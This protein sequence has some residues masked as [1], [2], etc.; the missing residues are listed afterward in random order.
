MNRAQFFASAAGDDVSFIEHL[1]R[2]GNRY[3]LDKA[4]T[5]NSLFGALSGGVID[6]K[7]PDIPR[8]D[9]FSTLEK[10]N[11]EK[12]LIGIYLSAHPLDDYRLELTH[13]CNTRLHELD[14]LFAV[15]KR[16]VI[17]GGMVT[18]TRRGTTKKGTPFGIFT[19]EDYSGAYEFPLFG[20]DLPKFGNFIEKGYFIMIRGNVVPKRFNQEER[21]FK[22]NQIDFLSEVRTGKIES[23]TVSIPLPSLTQSFVTELVDMTSDTTGDVLLKFNII[24]P[25]N[26]NH[27]KLFSRNKRISL[28]NDLVKY[29]DENPDVTFSINN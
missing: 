4:S 14:D 29:F 1:I 17:V 11:R 7:K 3:Q 26:N 27:I 21:E 2:Y 8:C 12:D 9:E 6:I 22:I 23:V 5:Q 19:L 13:F 25:A 20:N 10:L 16:E 15:N 18:A 24:D 28:T